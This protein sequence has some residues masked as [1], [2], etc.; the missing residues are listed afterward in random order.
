MSVLDGEVTDRHPH[1]DALARGVMV[2]LS[3]TD[4]SAG[5]DSV[6]FA[7]SKPFWLFCAARVARDPPRGLVPSPRRRRAA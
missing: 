6:L 4:P 5:Q 2:E 7:G 1:N 3:L